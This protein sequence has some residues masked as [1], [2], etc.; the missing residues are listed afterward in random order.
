MARKTPPFVHYPEWTNAR[1]WAF[2]RSALRSAWSRY[3]PKFKVLAKAKRNY[4]GT[5][6]QQ[7][8]EYHCAMCGEWFKAKDVSVDHIVP[9]GTLTT[10]EDL[11]NFVRN[12]FVSEDMLRVLCNT[13][14]ASVTKEQRR[15]AKEDKE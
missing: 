8:Y 12:L 13:C 6:K 14:H 15:A 1:F 11:P 5:N 9:A 3:P 2:V 7:K 10:Y 4:E